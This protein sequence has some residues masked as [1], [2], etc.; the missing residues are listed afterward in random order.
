MR[1]HALVFGLASIGI[2][3]VLLV[4]LLFLARHFAEDTFTVFAV[5]MIVTFLLVNTVYALWENRR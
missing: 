4:A 3:L 2:S 1:N 5:V